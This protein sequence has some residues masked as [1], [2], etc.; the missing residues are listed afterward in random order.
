MRAPRW[1]ASF[2]LV[3]LT[4]ASAASAAP[5][6]LKLD[7]PSNSAMAIPT[8]NLNDVGVFG[9]V[10]GTAPD[11]WLFKV[12]SNVG[13]VESGAVG[14][15]LIV[16]IGGI[17]LFN[18]PPATSLVLKLFDGST[19]LTP[20]YNG[21]ELTFNNL[22]SGNTYR[23]EVSGISG[24]YSGEVTPSP[25]PLPAAAWLLL[26]GIAGVGAFARRKRQSEE[27]LV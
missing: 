22:L 25:V 5:V 24:F 19:W 3:T 6:G 18:S 23:L 12:S 9:N 4:W 17:V 2:A 11:N 21:N 10:L 13:G 15:P 8:L 7:V 16:T 14:Q 20:S 27:A 1:I 26:S